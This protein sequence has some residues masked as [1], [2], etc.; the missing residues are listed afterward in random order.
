MKI[1][2]SNGKK[3]KIWVNHINPNSSF[4]STEQIF[5]Y[6]K[7][8][9]GTFVDI[10]EDDKLIGE[11]RSRLHK[12]DENKF[13]KHLGLKL[14]LKQAMKQASFKKSIRTEIWNAVFSNKYN[15]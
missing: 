6:E 9:P 8:G 10:F 12:E 3:L 1:T 7:Y 15:N 2:L 5:L 4:Y 13:N 11:G 14:S